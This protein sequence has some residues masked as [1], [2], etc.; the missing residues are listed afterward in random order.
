MK[1][2]GLY[3]RVSTTEQSEH[4]YSIDE[5]KER[6]MAY[7]VAKGWNPVGP[8]VDPAYS[9]GDLNRPGLQKLISEIKSLDLVL[10]YKLDRLSRR[11]KDTLFLIEDVLLKNKVDIV[12]L[13]E[14]LDTT[15]PFGRAAIGILAAFAQLE[16]DTFKERSL[17]GRT[18]RARTGK[19]VGSSRPPIGYRYDDLGLI[20]DEYEAEQVK[21]VYSLYLQGHGLQKIAEIMKSK[22]YTHKYGDWSWWGGVATMLKNSVYIGKVKF[23]KQEF[24]GQHEPIID[25]NTF[26]QVQNLLEKRQTGQLYKRHSPFSHLLYCSECGAKMFYLKKK[27]REA[28]YYCY[29]RYG[30]PKSQVK[31]PNCQMRIWPAHELDELILS[32]IDLL[33]NDKSIL[34]HITNHQPNIG[35]R[36]RLTEIEKQVN[37]LLELYQ[38]NDMPIK[39]LTE[40]IKSLHDE[41]NK[42][43]AMIS[44]EKHQKQD[45][46]EIRQVAKQIRASWPK[47]DISGKII[48]IDKL[49][50][51][52]LVTPDNIKPKWTFADE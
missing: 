7:C 33:H 30:K 28:K 5:Q 29:S 49:I 46:Q 36:R 31:D 39:Q 25:T 43:E 13:Q 1:N 23:N 21:I 14:N 37:K 40:K 51:G 10:V 3:I 42:L 8:Y 9:G 16:R 17:L 24:D 47:L 41:R 32:Q 52:V 27:N 45:A 4:G 35:A 48:L 20:I 38:F 18:G 34:P 11:Q 26:N 44:A 2:A 15:S 22:G 19:W 12:S 50:S 6:L